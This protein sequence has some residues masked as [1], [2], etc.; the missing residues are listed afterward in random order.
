MIR[1]L[2]SGLR[3]TADRICLK[4]LICSAANSVSGPDLQVAI[5]KVGSVTRDN[6]SAIN[7]LFIYN[8][9]S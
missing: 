1:P 3:S 5:L 7:C 9:Q 8:F 6:V 2:P 4:K